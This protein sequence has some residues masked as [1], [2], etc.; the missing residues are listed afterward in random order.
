MYYPVYLDLSGRRCVVV[1]GG[2]VAERKV[3]AL[4]RCGA[5]VTVISPTLT[6]K[7]ADLVQRGEIEHRARSYQSGDLEGGRV[8][9]GATDDR[10]TNMAVFEE[11]EARGILANVVDDPPLCTFI[12]P[13]TVTRGDLQIAIS[14]GGASPAMAKRIRAGLEDEFGEEY[15]ML[16]ALMREF[17][18]LVMARVPSPAARRRIFDAVA[19]SDV[20]DRIRAGVNVSA[21]DLVEEFAAGQPPTAT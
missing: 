6:E 8:V 12:V 16:M 10:P 18:S 19:D 13:S 7:L 15:A 9:F 14:T 2:E 4:V 17:R 11:A 20:L 21:E 5:A 1:G 3:E